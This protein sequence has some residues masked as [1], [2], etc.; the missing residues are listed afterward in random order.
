MSFDA[1]ISS[2]ITTGIRVVG[3]YQINYNWFN[4]PYAVSQYKSF[5]LRHAWLNLLDERMTT[6][7][8]NQVAIVQEATFPLR[9]KAETVSQLPNTTASGWFSIT[10][11]AELF[12]YDAR[13]PAHTHT[14]KRELVCVPSQRRTPSWTPGSFASRLEDETAKTPLRHSTLLSN[15]SLGNTRQTKTAK[16]CL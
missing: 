9:P 4:E 7:R 10:A 13:P 1:R 6:G 5:I 16:P 15:F 8:I 11:V 2:R 14:H 3:E 12:P